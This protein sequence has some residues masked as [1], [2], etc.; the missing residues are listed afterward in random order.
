[1]ETG[2][3]KV[4]NHMRNA[5]YTLK[6]VN[7]INR[8]TIIANKNANCLPF[9]KKISKSKE[10]ENRINSTNY[11]KIKSIILFYSFESVFS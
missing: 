2:G 4:L 1:M 7:F 8:Q 11:L 6:Y 5:F 3:N 10:R 9:Q